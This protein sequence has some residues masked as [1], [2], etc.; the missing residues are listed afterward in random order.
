MEVTREG[1]VVGKKSLFNFIA[2]FEVLAVEGRTKKGGGD[3]RGRKKFDLTA[4][5]CI[6]GPK[7]RNSKYNTHD[8]TFSFILSPS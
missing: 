1:S 5:Y 6:L 2:R 8:C 7:S 3:K 4:I